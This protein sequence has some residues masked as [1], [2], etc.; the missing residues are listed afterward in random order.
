MQ[1]NVIVKTGYLP[2]YVIGHVTEKPC[3]DLTERFG[4]LCHSLGRIGG[5]YLLRCL[6]IK[7]YSTSVRQT[8]NYSV[9]VWGVLRKI[10][11]LSSI[12]IDSFVGLRPPNIGLSRLTLRKVIRLAIA[13]HRPACPFLS[14]ATKTKSPAL[15][16]N[17]LAHTVSGMDLLAGLAG[18]LGG[19]VGLAGPLTLADSQN[20]SSGLVGV[21][22]VRP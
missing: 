6:S 1:S 19:F 15:S 5:P 16:I 9:S 21:Q 11:S 18:W 4:Q 20:R 8:W 10:L 2:G 22:G 3:F 17:R 7:P 13:A 12:E 14:F